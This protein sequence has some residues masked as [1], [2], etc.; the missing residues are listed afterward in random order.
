[1]HVRSILA[2]LQVR[3]R[4]QAVLVAHKE[5]VVPGPGAPSGRS[6]LTET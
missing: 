1:M 5:G 3:D 6:G 4:V 2:R